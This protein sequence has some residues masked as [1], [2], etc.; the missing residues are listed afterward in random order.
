MVIHLHL[1]QL[2]EL[3]FAVVDLEREV[4]ARNVPVV[5]FHALIMAREKQKRTDKNRQKPTNRAGEKTG[6]IK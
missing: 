6:A 3:L 1:R 5:Y 2:G 4:F